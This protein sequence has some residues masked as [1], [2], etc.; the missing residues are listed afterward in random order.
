MPLHS[1]SESSLPLGSSFA[2]SGGRTTCLHD[3]S[4]HS[5]VSTWC[6]SFPSH[7]LR[8]HPSILRT[9]IR[10]RRRSTSRSIGWAA[11]FLSPFRGLVRVRQRLSAS[12]T[13]R[14]IGDGVVTANR[15]LSSWLADAKA[16]ESRPRHAYTGPLQIFASRQGDRGGRSTR[17]FA[18]GVGSDGDGGRT[19]SS[20]KKA[21]TPCPYLLQLPQRIISN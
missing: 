8:T 17:I 10:R 2:T 7:R 19:A 16:K 5:A 1:A 6:P 21:G 3:R 4:F 9:C 13:C 18:R 14:W 20:P 11:C 12:T 15:S